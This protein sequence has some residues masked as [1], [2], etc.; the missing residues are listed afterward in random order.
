MSEKSCVLNSNLMTTSS[1]TKHVCH[2][3][4]LYALS[5]DFNYDDFLLEIETSI[6]HDTKKNDDDDDDNGVSHEEQMTVKRKE[7]YDKLIFSLIQ[8][9]AASKTSGSSTK[10]TGLNSLLSSV[11]IPISMATLG[12]KDDKNEE[13]N[14]KSCS[15]DKHSENKRIHS[16]KQSKSCC[17]G[18]VQLIEA[19]VKRCKAGN[20]THNS[21][22][23]AAPKTKSSASTKTIQEK[24]DNYCMFW[25]NTGAKYLSKDMFTFQ[26][27]KVMNVSDTAV[28]SKNALHDNRSTCTSNCR[29]SNEAL[30][31]KVHEKSW[32]LIK[33]NGVRPSRSTNVTSTTEPKS[34][35][36]NQNTKRS[37]HNE[38]STNISSK[39]S[40][41][42][43]PDNDNEEE[44]KC[45]VVEIRHGDILTISIPSKL[46]HYSNR[47]KQSSLSV[48][49]L[50]RMNMNFIFL[51]IDESLMKCY[52]SNDSNNDLCNKNDSR[53]GLSSRTIMDEKMISRDLYVETPKKKNLS[54]NKD[55]DRQ[56]K[57]TAI[58]TESSSATSS[59]QQQS[60][61]GFF[62][63]LRK[64]R[65]LDR[66]YSTTAT[67]NDNYHS[68]PTSTI[69]YSSTRT[70]TN[71]NAPDTCS[72]LGKKSQ[73][74]SP[75]EEYSEESALLS[76][77]HCSLAEEQQH[78]NDDN[79]YHLVAP[80]TTIKEDDNMLQHDNLHEKK[81]YNDNM[82]N[83]LLSSLSLKQLTLLQNEMFTGNNDNPN[84]NSVSTNSRMTMDCFQSTLLDIAIRH[85]KEV[86]EM[87]KEDCTTTR[88]SVNVCF[89]QL[90]EKTTITDSMCKVLECEEANNY[91]EQT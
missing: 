81:N 4:V 26:Q 24:I 67:K 89:P 10:H 13:Q 14:E 70:T 55:D 34:I 59:L 76:M 78:G 63:T 30:L 5:H 46:L 69:N 41:Q 27:M 3:Y 8:S 35:Q 20:A 44:K 36:L 91:D 16:K 83:P 12:S 47:R 84:N 54:F 87:N 79:E 71:T 39:H 72:Q 9:H 53:N 40:E 31:M 11:S 50:S 17:I 57:D 21:T 60:S 7:M 42:F 22:T 82:E 37:K 62:A 38:L 52:Y 49:K 25:C 80:T 66:Q 51:C 64:K 68:T 43:Q 6:N 77:H 15:S 90:L 75:L 23:I 88:S 74:M 1:S 28:K 32:K 58:T 48:T 18:R 45:R 56:S 33:L 61:S 85:K 19:T 65:K 73:S 29:T 2:Q 86:G